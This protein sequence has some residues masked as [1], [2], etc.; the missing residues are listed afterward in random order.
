M[1]L[2]N[3]QSRLPITVRAGCCYYVKGLPRETSAGARRQRLQ[4][5]VRVIA[6]RRAKRSR[7]SATRFEGFEG[8]RSVA[9]R[10]V[11]WQRERTANQAEPSTAWSPE[12]PDPGTPQNFP[13][14]GFPKE[15]RAK[16]SWLAG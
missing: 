15:P 10:L 2:V 3:W 8:T 16:A 5:A 14:R 7:G 6:R 4:N 9:V 12:T 13:A 11:G 1:S